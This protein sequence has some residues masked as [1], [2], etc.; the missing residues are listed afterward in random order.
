M[1]FGISDVFSNEIMHETEGPFISLYQPTHR[2]RPH[3]KQDIIRFKNLVQQIEN[4]LKQKYSAKEIAQ[5]LKPFNELEENKIFWNNTTDGLA[6]LANKNRHTIYKLPRSVEELAVVSNSFHIKPLIR[7]FQSADRYHLL[8]LNRKRFTLYEG[9]RYGFEEVEL[10]PNLPRTIEDVLGDDYSDP[11]LSQGTYAGTGTPVFH[12]HGSRK[13]VIDKDTEKYFRYVD[14]F[15]ADTFSKPTG[16][17]L[18]LV[19]LEEHHGLFRK[20]SNNPYLLEDGIKVDYE[21]LSVEKM[22]K[23]AWK[24]IEPFYL[25]RTQEMVDRYN[26]ERSKFL[27][28]EDLVEVARAVFQNNVEILIIEADKI[29]PGKINKETGKIERGNLDDPGIG[30]ILDDLAV[31]AYRSGSEVVILPKERMPSKTGVAVIYRY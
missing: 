17:P 5:I 8:G 9:N 22:H 3:N 4:S 31:M 16:L 18:I 26:L 28:S 24:V 6:I 10:D 27:A 12:G 21:T 14:K 30:D 15:I 25:Q 23:D 13:D 2:H 29:E 11:Y 7:V 19:A 1:L 20:I